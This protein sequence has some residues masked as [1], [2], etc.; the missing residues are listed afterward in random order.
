MNKADYTPWCGSASARYQVKVLR[1]KSLRSPKEVRIC[2]QP[3]FRDNSFPLCLY[4]SDQLCRFQTCKPHGFVREG[5][6]KGV[7]SMNKQH[8]TKSIVKLSSSLSIY[9]SLSHTHKHT[10]IDN[11]QEKKN[12]PKSIHFCNLTITI[13]YLILL[14]CLWNNK[15][16]DFYVKFQATSNSLLSYIWS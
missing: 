14:N 3:S 5:W 16:I 2:L 11:T 7:V 13:F 15:E 4:P 9:I 1:E 8:H 10:H 6:G 12:L